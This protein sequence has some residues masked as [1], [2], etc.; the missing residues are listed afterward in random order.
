VL[1]NFCLSSLHVF[2]FSSF[3]HAFAVPATPSATVSNRRCQFAK[4]AY[5][6]QI[7]ATGGSGKFQYRAGHDPSFWDGNTI[8]LYSSADTA[9]VRDVVTGEISRTSFTDP[10]ST[11]WPLT[12]AATAIA[13]GGRVTLTANGGAA[14][15][16]YSLDGGTAQS[17]NI[18]NLVSSGMHTYTITD[19]YGCSTTGSV[20][21]PGVAEVSAKI[22][23]TQ[24]TCSGGADGRIVASDV[25][26][27]IG[28]FQYAVSSTNVSRP[29][30]VSGSFLNLPAG[31]YILIITDLGNANIQTTF[32]SNILYEQIRGLD[33]SW[34]LLVRRYSDPNSPTLIVNPN[35]LFDQLWEFFLDGLVVARGRSEPGG[36]ALTVSTYGNHTVLLRSA[37]GCATP[38]KTIYYYPQRTYQSG[39]HRFNCHQIW[40]T[41]GFCL[42]SNTNQ[43]VFPMLQTHSVPMY[44][45]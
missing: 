16:S 17:S 27:G 40:S 44:R 24:V 1:S 14:P 6:V 28:P 39:V 12:G 43:C 10:Y 42:G 20:N 21:V 35:G 19:A 2:T 23:L 26:G 7:T 9:F 3:S 18:F 31:D 13:A 32:P 25:T 38:A 4:L 41:M 15:Y 36:R 11:W 33:F 29:N 5:D 8:V 34:Q 37:L 30:Q 45:M 22:T